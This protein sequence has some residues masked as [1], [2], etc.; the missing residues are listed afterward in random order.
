M[1]QPIQVA[2]VGGGVAA[3]AACH[4]LFAQGIEPV[5]V[6]PQHPVDHQWVGESLS[7]QGVRV[8]DSMGLCGLLEHPAHRPANTRFAAWGRAALIENHASTSVYGAGMVID[9]GIFETGL[10][11]QVQLAPCRAYLTRAERIDGG[12]ELSL[13]AG[14]SLRVAHVVDASGRA[15]VFARRYT[16]YCR[17]DQLIAAVAILTRKNN[18][19]EPTPATIIEA[20]PCGW[21]YAALL[22]GERLVVAYFSDPD[23]LP[24]GL[25]RHPNVWRDLIASSTHVSHWL[26]ETGFQPQAAPRLHSAGTTW[27]QTPAVSY[28]D[29]ASWIAAGDA[30][31]SLDPL[32]SHGLTTALWGGWQAGLAMAARVRGLA[33]TAFPDYAA[34]IHAGRTR[35]M[36]ERASIYRLE[37]R[38][39][40]MP[41]WCRR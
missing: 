30:A 40:S 18:D 17:H 35:Y 9:R 21:W 7:A 37:H 39:A 12:F 26:A 19:V 14:D 10:L 23:L 5:W 2:V 20:T 16:E 28:S 4:T 38:Y 32:S 25:S 24:R 27:L 3:A 41:F 13:S 8:L 29:G 33:G 11:Q 6:A 1:S 36:Q 15:A 31:L 22:T 34:K